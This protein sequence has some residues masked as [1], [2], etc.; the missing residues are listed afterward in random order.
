[1]LK[2]VSHGYFMLVHRPSFL[3]RPA[4][5]FNTKA[6]LELNQ[7]KAAFLPGTMRVAPLHCTLE[8]SLDT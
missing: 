2:R 6:L 3:L 7:L 1:M 5:S 8:V 4:P